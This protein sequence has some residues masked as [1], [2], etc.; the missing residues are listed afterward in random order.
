MATKDLSREYLEEAWDLARQH[1]P[2]WAYASIHDEAR[3][4]GGGRARHRPEPEPVLCAKCGLP[5]DAPEHAGELPK[6][7]PAIEILKYELPE[8]SLPSFGS[9]GARVLF[10]GA[11]PSPL[12]VARGEPLT[13]AA[14]RLFRE[15]YLPAMGLAREHVAIAHL[16]PTALKAG[17]PSMLD[18]QKWRSWLE[19]EIKRIQPGVVVALG[20]VAKAALGEVA[21][22]TLPHPRAVAL[23]EAAGR[24]VEATGAELVRKFARVRKALTD[25]RSGETSPNS[26]G[27][28]APIHGDTA[29]ASK[30]SDSGSASGDGE[31][32]DTGREVRIVKALAAEQVVLGV[33]LD[34][35]MVDAHNDWTPPK[36][37]EAT[38]EAW[39]QKSSVIGLQH[40]GKADAYPVQS[41]TM[42]YPSQRDY[43]AAMREEPHKVLRTK[44]GNQVVH[45]GAWVLKTKVP[46]PKIWADIM[47]EKIT[48]YSI[49]GFSTRTK[50]PITAMPKVEYV[51][52]T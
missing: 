1:L 8:G 9:E 43:E 29:G 31:A 44:I 38:A 36:E 18:Q 48:G 33:V 3:R 6:P 4:I 28:S 35:Y 39:L 2:G 16:V 32:S 47:S 42:P 7:P 46:S 22:L 40:G 23:R 25:F 30:A 45:S 41:F 27:R 52:A 5:P 37:I 13:G 14:G 49:G 12:D 17:E 19:S 51:D 34:P 21:L 26:E 15:T 10:I 50:V 20:N 11:A 24:P